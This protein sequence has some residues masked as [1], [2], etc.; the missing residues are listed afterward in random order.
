MKKYQIAVVGSSPILMIKA[1]QQ[2]LL[3][4]DTVLY[5]KESFLGGAWC[6]GYRFGRHIDNG[7]HFLYYSKD[8][9]RFKGFL[10]ANYSLDLKRLSHRPRGDSRLFFDFPEF[11]FHSTHENFYKK[12]LRYIDFSR[13]KRV[14]HGLTC[15]NP[16]YYFNHGTIGLIQRLEALYLSLGGTIKTNSLVKE[17]SITTSGN[18]NVLLS[19]SDQRHFSEKL[20]ISSRALLMPNTISIDSQPYQFTNL[21]S[22]SSL[23]QIFLLISEPGP[24]KFSAFK[25]IDPIIFIA[26]DSRAFMNEH[27]DN[28]NEAVFIFAL[29]KNISHNLIDYNY[30]LKALMDRK[31]ISKSSKIKEVQHH[32]DDIINV[33]PSQITSFNNIKNNPVEIVFYNNLS[34]E[35]AKLYKFNNL[36]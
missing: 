7:A 14:I 16:Y 11:S 1:I 34:N 29:N 8:L 5:E 27:Q 36:K 6:T 15:R 13:F 19:I 23:T 33:C 28:L 3:G 24:I 10:N 32:E 30:L 17:I 26:V 22:G 25:F 35:L 2:Q 18:G 31:L 4:N 12:F 21:D 9:L 20:I